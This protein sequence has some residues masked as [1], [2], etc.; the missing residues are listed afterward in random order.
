MLGKIDLPS[1]KTI[2]E[3]GCRQGKISADL[4]QSYS[5]QK[6]TAIDKQIIAFD[7]LL[8]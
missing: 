2:L 8:L 5:N 6:F 7:N 3:L 4:A 1:H